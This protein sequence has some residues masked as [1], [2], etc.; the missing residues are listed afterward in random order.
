MGWLDSVVGAISGSASGQPGGQ[1]DLLH[2]V[3]AMLAQDGQG[4]GLSGLVAKFQQGGLG[5][6]VSSWV[7]TGRNLPI[8]PEQLQQVL[9]SESISGLAAKLGMSSDDV[10]HH[11][12]Q[13]LP[14][15]VDQ[16]T[17]DGQLPDASAG[18]LGDIGA[19]LGRFQPR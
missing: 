8:S 12:S 10:G 11:L 7:G 3:L 6:I 14:Q 9:G 13:W 1:A 5:D 17:P 4:A 16:L 15:A 2:A 18:G 19:I